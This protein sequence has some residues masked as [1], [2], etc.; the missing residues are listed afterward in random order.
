MAKTSAIQKNDRRKALAAKFAPRRAELRLIIE[1]TSSSEEAKDAA[2]FEL[3]Q[4]PRNSNP[5]RVRNRCTFTGRS[6]AVYRRFGICRVTL[7]ELAHE[8]KIPGMRKS[9]W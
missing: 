5:N 4:M 6:R 7:R 9:S 1:N 2:R 8:G 3:S